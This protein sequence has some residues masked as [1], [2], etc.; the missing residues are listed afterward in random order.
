MPTIDDLLA[1]ARRGLHRI[2]AADV[3]AEV[4]AGAVLVDIRPAGQRAAEGEADG[5]LVVER[6]V[7]EWRCD[8]ASDARLPEAVDHDVRWIILCSQGYTSSLA[9]ASLQQLGLHRATDVIGGHQAL[10]ALDGD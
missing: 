1:A 9:A 8:P 4:A 7:L 10:R 6:N 3:A 5:A 2:E